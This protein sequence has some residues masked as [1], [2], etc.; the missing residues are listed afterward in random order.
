MVIFQDQLPNQ[1]D[2]HYHI[3]KLLCLC[4]RPTG[5]STF[6]ESLLRHS[7]V[8]RSWEKLPQMAERHGLA[9]LVYHHLREAGVTM[10]TQVDRTLK[11]SYLTHRHANFE[12]M[13]ALVEIA[14]AYREAGIG[15]LALKGAALANTIYPETT[16]RCM[17]DL[18][19]MV[20]IGDADKA[21]L[22]LKSLGF[23]IHETTSIHPKPFS[24]HFPPA[25]RTTANVRVMVELH[26][27]LFAR[28]KLIPTGTFGKLIPNAIPFTI[29]DITVDTLG[30]VHMLWH[31]YIH[32]VGKLQLVEQFRLIHVADLVGLVETYADHIDWL[33]LKNFSQQ[34][35]HAILMLSLFT[36]WS[37]AVK[38][39]LPF[40]TELK[41]QFKDFPQLPLAMEINSRNRKKWL[42]R[43]FLDIII[44]PDW[45]VC[46]FQGNHPARFNKFNH[47]VS[48]PLHQIG[49]FATNLAGYY[50]RK[51]YRTWRKRP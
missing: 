27:H 30:P 4:A 36:P 48:Y 6:Y 31:T 17:C 51:A 43:F 39:R 24:H 11:A 7:S 3:M 13:A 50:I 21:R 20:A 8:I 34:T 9:P 41:F 2:N 47:H 33:Q 19:L 18:D 49:S 32:A 44:Q 40:E 16:L 14:T 38:Q 12:R 37:P 1:T 46:F 28:S 29:N 25:T 45:W 15:M 26:H 22:L 42:S 23:D 10:P 5:H 35:Y